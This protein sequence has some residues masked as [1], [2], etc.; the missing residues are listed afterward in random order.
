MRSSARSRRRTLRKPCIARS[1]STT[2]LRRRTRLRR[3]APHARGGVTPETRQRENP[4]RRRLFVAEPRSLRRD[5]GATASDGPTVDRHA[6]VWRVRT[7]RAPRA[8]GP[9]LLHL[10][11]PPARAPAPTRR[12]RERA[13]TCDVERRRPRRPR[14][15]HDASARPRE[16]ADRPPA[17]RSRSS[18]FTCSVHRRRLRP[19]AN[20]LHADAVP[21][22][23]LFIHRIS[24]RVRP[25][26]AEAATRDARGRA[27]DGRRDRSTSPS[28]AARA[29]VRIHLAGRA[30]TCA[31]ASTIPTRTLF[32]PA[33]PAPVLFIHPR[34]SACARAV[35]KP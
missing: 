24:I 1:P 8:A 31:V 27:S 17:R 11:C 28:S 18:F 20:A 4:H 35:R 2:A 13:R 9:F 10:L 32:T 12:R 6:P 25:C 3:H 7:V 16:L 21:D 26:C 29:Q 14:A 34:T 22:P 5:P 15:R 19:H 33:G 30:P 23:L